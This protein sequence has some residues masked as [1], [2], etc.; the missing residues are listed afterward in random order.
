MLKHGIIAEDKFYNDSML[1][2]V[3]VRMPEPSFP[4]DVE[5]QKFFLLVSVRCAF[6]FGL[7]GDGSSKRK[8][9]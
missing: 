6:C 9:N 3:A 5:I 2:Y 8:G 4:P 1:S 7:N